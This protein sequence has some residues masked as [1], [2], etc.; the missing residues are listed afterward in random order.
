[1]TLKMYDDLRVNSHMSFQVE[2]SNKRFSADYNEEYI[3][4]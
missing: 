4:N 1:M 2:W 3:K